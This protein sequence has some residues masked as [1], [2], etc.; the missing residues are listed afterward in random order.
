M[1]TGKIL[2]PFARKLVLTALV[3]LILYLAW[4]LPAARY[5]FLCS[6]L[7]GYVWLSRN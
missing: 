6:C 3:F 5:C 2:T 4:P 1:N 7:T